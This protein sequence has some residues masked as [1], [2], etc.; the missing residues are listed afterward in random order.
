MQY[1]FHFPP[2]EFSKRRPSELVIWV[3]PIENSLVTVLGVVTL[4][5][6]KLIAVLVERGV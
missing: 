6:E 2:I 5:F 3:L 1:L 4:P